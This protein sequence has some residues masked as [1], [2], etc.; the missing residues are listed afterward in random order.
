MSSAESARLSSQ[1]AE[2]L[3]QRTEGTIIKK[4]HIFRGKGIVPY[5]VDA[6]YQAFLEGILHHEEFRGAVPPK[7]LSNVV[8]AKKFKRPGKDV[9]Y[10]KK[11]VDGLYVLGEIYRDV[12]YVGLHAW[13]YSSAGKTIRDQSH[14]R[15]LQ[16][17]RDGTLTHFP[18]YPFTFAGANLLRTYRGLGLLWETKVEKVKVYFPT[19][20]F[21][22]MSV[23]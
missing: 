20:R 1:S 12:G 19:A 9:M 8:E 15:V 23:R 22:K 5:Y 10:A 21:V 18:I 2:D 11:F 3:E 13:A 14:E 6:E 16:G 17:I 4:P 7:V